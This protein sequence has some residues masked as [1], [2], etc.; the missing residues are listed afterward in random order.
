VKLDADLVLPTD[1][2]EKI[3]NAFKNNSEI[4]VCG[5]F[6]CIYKK[7]G[8]FKESCSFRIR[9][10]IK[11]YTYLCLIKIFPL[12]DDIGWDEIDEVKAVSVGWNAKILDI[13]VVHMRKTKSRCKSKLNLFFRS[14]ISNY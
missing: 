2:F 7:N 4:G 8:C 6:C 5:G 13:P 14:G 9:G 10:A 11:A 1:Y 12:I 3:L